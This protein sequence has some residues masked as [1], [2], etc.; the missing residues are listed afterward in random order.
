MVDQL[1]KIARRHGRTCA[2][3]AI[4]WVLRRPEVTA[5]IVGAR[6]PDQILETVNASNWSL[7]QEDIDD[8]ERL[9]MER[10]QKLT[11]SV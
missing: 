5:A 10:Q 3:L 4:S 11:G 1:K 7:S 2:Q 6:R 9:L 8:I